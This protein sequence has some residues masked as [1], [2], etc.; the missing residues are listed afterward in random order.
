MAGVDFRMNPPSVAPPLPAGLS[1]EG[2]GS[3]RVLSI[4]W[5]NMA[6]WALLPLGMV[7]AVIPV[8]LFFKLSDLPWNDPIQLLVVVFG[9]VGLVFTYLVIRRL[10]NVTR[11]E[12]TPE[13]IR[14]SHGPVPWR[15]P[16]E[17]ATETIR[18]VEVRPYQW[19]YE[20]SVAT[21]YHVWTVHEDGRESLLLGR[22]TDA[23]QANHV[24]DEIQRVLD[25]RAVEMR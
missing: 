11:L 7:A 18:T 21:H 10:V 22:D 15:R 16:F 4:H 12:V 17:V 9:V 25:A 14:I 3:K 23:E 19:R 5:R 13:R 8:G 1:V 24:R 2:S 6:S 20:G